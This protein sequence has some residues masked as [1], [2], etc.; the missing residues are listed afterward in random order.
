MTWLLI[1]VVLQISPTDT[2]VK[3]SEVIDTFYNDRECIK[4]MQDIFAK[5]EAE[6]SK[7]PKMVNFGCVPLKGRGI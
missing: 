4:A 2:F 3:H 1:M 5:A 7:V 6:G